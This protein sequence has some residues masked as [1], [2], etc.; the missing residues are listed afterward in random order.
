[1]ASI[2]KAFN[3]S[4]VN[5]GSANRYQSERFQNKDVMMCP[6][7][8]SH[9]TTGRVNDDDSSYTKLAGCNLAGDRV[10]IENKHR[11]NKAESFS[12]NEYGIKGQ[13]YDKNFDMSPKTTYDSAVYNEVMRNKVLLREYQKDQLNRQM[14]G[15]D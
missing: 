5:T 7:W 11:L 15:M 12:L 6:V 13:F 1:M 14:S 10:K 2:K 3:G 8:N 4:K 9:D